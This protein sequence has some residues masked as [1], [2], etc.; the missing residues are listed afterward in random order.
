MTGLVTASPFA[1]RETGDDPVPAD[2]LLHP[3]ALV[4]LAVLVLNDHVLKEITPSPL[5]GI[6]SD[7]AGIVLFPL[8]LQAGWELLSR[9][10]RH[11]SS[12]R[13]IVVACVAT[14][15]AFAAVELIPVAA[16]LYRYGLGALQ[17]SAAAPMT[18]LGSDPVPALRP[19]VAV[20]DPL[21]LLAL[22]ALVIPWSIG[23]C[24]TRRPRA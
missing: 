19:V 3:I 23:R 2:G 22:P 21:D 5:T 24:R 16:D 13:A 18:A 17:W 12:G 9:G 20:A 11:P 7:V 15:I 1:T 6:L 10:R 14:G 8:V 4:A